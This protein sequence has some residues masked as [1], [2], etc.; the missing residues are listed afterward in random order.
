M[1]TIVDRK[2]KK[3]EPVFSGTVNELL[4]KHYKS[5]IRGFSETAFI[6]KAGTKEGLFLIVFELVVLADQ[7]NTTY[8]GLAFVEVEKYVDIEIIVRDKS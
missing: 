2:T 4:D 8:T 1:N 6:G 3:N 7:P 5:C